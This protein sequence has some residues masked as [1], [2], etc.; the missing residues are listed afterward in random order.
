MDYEKEIKTIKLK[1]LKKFA[2]ELYSRIY[3]EGL[4]YGNLR[5]ETVSEAVEVLRKKLAAKPLAE[6]KRFINTVRQLSTGASHTFTRKMQVENSAV[7]TDI[8]VGQRSPEL[9]SA[10]MVI[11][12]LIQPQFYN[13][14]RTSQQLGYIVN[15]GMTVLEKTLGLIFIIQSGE[16]NTEILEQ[17]MGA[18]LEK[19]NDYLKELPDA[20]LNK[21][22]KSVLNSKLQKTNS[23][24]AEAVRLFTIAFEQNAEFDVNSR[25]IRALEKLTREDIMDV[26]NSYLLTSKQ[27]KLI[28]RMSGM[29]YNA[30]NSSGER[31][32]SAAKFKKLYACPQYCLP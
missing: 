16:Y 27:R 31:I 24:T 10:L 9:L 3:I 5:A 4:A 23:V 30:G 11:D 12:N 19:F 20:E 8:Q 15:S 2:A 25:E 13:D 17:R 6:S 22:K 14:L 21:I 7:V 32:S 26:V 29:D 28:L 18:F 1:D